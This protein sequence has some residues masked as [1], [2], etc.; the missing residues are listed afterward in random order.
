MLPSPHQSWT[1]AVRADKLP[2]GSTGALWIGRRESF[3]KRRE[4]SEASGEIHNNP[5]APH[6]RRARVQRP[7][8]SGH[9]YLRGDRLTDIWHRLSYSER[10]RLADDIGACVA[11]LRKI[12]NNTPYLFADTLGGPMFD[13]RMPDDG[14]PPVNSESDFYNL[15]TRHLDCTAAELF[16]EETFR[17]LRQDHQSYFSHSDMNPYNLLLEGGRLSGIIDWECVGYKLEYWEFTTAMR[18]SYTPPRQAIFRRALGG[19]YEKELEIEGILWQNTTP[20]D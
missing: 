2:T 17:K 6:S 14:G 3:Q 5:S 9:T 13:W 12:P 11:K 15:L 20:F 18:F 8:I 4:C 16:G 1:L 7:D 19:Q 10:A